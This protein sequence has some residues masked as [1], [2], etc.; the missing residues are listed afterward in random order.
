[1]ITGSVDQGEMI[2]LLLNASNNYGLKYMKQ[3]LTG[4]QGETEKSII[5]GYFNMSLNN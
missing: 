3:K 1:M 2:K 5:M 4:P